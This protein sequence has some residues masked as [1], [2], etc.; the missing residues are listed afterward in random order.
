MQSGC[1][2][3]PAP[4]AKVMSLPVNVTKYREHVSTV[5]RR[6][7]IARC[8]VGSN[9]FEPYANDDLGIER[10]DAEQ[11][12]SLLKSKRTGEWLQIPSVRRPAVILL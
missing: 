10:I 12:F 8:R 7:R 4:G 6:T 3:L 2:F 1:H 5:T 9:N 11:L